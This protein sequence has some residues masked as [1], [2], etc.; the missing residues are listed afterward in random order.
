M[1]KLPKI[2]GVI[3]RRLLVNFRARPEVVADFLP[4]PF[5]PKLH[6]GWSILGICLIRLEG[7][8][9]VGLPEF[10]G[11]ASENAAHRIAVTWNGGKDDGVFIPR[12]DT[13]SMLNH[14]AGGRL[15][16]GEHHRAR[17]D[18]VDDGEQ[19]SLRVRAANPSMHLSVKGRKVDHMP[20]TSVFFSLRQS[21]DFF[22]GGAVGYSVTRDCCRFDGIRLETAGW[23]VSPFE[24]EEVGSSFF[25]DTELFPANSILYDHALIMRDLPHRWIQESDIISEQPGKND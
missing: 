6:D 12:R 5:E 15:F 16:P 17:F 22:K 7:I 14:L 4:D 9:A 2:Q 18:V 25:S 21:S 1:M 11:I 20:D 13:D 23:E 3:R 8:R 19:V 10:L 24:V